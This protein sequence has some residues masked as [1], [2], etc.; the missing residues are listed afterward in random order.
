MPIIID[1]VIVAVL[2]IFMI[3]GIKR[4]FFLMLLP[5][6]SIVLAIILGFALKAPVRK[7]L[8]KTPLESKISASVTQLLEKTLS[9]NGS[10]DAVKEGG[11]ENNADNEVSK[12]EGEAAVKDTGIP[13]YIAD[14]VKKWASGNEGNVYGEGSDTAAV[15]GS[16]I[17]SFAVDL[18]AFLIIAVIVIIALLIIK[19]IFKKTRQLNIPVLHQLGSVGGAIAGVALGAAIL[20]GIAFIIGMLASCG[21]MTGF[22]DSLRKSFIG[23]FIYNHNLIGQLVALV[24][25]KF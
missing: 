5:L 19:L 13:K 25:S 4:G 9:G 15:L 6:L 21:I 22:A 20:Y 23:G 2:L 7:L 11:E 3:V 17:A 12:E 18:I 8:D 1:I 16:K 10:E 14:M 24:K